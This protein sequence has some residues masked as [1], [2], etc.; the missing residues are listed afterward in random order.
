MTTLTLPEA[1]PP[2]CMAG[3]QPLAHA[4]RAARR[5][6][7][8]L[9]A[10]LIA[11]PPRYLPVTARRSTSPSRTHQPMRSQ[12]CSSSRRAACS[13]QT[14]SRWQLRT[15]C[16]SPR[17]ARA[18]ARVTPRRRRRL[19]QKV[20]LAGLQASGMACVMRSLHR[21]TPAQR[22]RE[23]ASGRAGAPVVREATVARRPPQRSRPQRRQ[24]RRLRRPCSSSCARA[25]RSR[26]LPAWRAGSAAIQPPRSC[27]ARARRRQP[28][29][30]ACAR[31]LHASAVPAHTGTAG[32]AAAN[33]AAACSA[34]SLA[35]ALGARAGWGQA[36]R[37]LRACRR[38][39]AAPPSRRAPR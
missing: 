11:A 13:A 32:L 24:E 19:R 18:S 9:A 20:V 27:R 4:S 6:P 25:K 7:R 28:S 30:T 2:R 31:P 12:R 8:P 26:G 5:A 38:A 35:V 33:L 15:T 36:A 37:A 23:R 3:V 16:S 21:H 1:H 39:G 14:S 34:A 17:R 22:A 10:I 29:S